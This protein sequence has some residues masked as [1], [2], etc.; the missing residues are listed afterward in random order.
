[1]LR[2][3]SVPSIIAAATLATLSLSARAV[4]PLSVSVADRE[5]TAQLQVP[6]GYAAELT[7]RFENVVGLSKD[8]LDIS[9]ETVS[10]L[11]TSLLQRLSGIGSIPMGFPMLLAIEVDPA[12][13]FSF[14]GTVDIELYTHDLKFVPGMPLRL[15]SAA[16]GGTFHDITVSNEGGS[17]RSG[18]TKGNFSDFIIALDLRPPQQAAGDKLQRLRSLL[19]Q[20]SADL[21]ASIYADLS[22]RLSE[23]ETAYAAN[24]L[25]TAVRYTEAFADAVKNYGADIP[26]VW[27]A[28][29]DLDN[30]SGELRAAA[31]TLRFS[32]TLAL[33]SL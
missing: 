17:Y 19:D 14:S 26:N 5:L 12:S 30:I 9:A 4:E 2:R 10:L 31:G 24:S 23:V 6:G 18:G 20:Y 3:T 16:H 21:D 13:G 22:G 32:L 27:G 8:S 7:L 25:V 33:N 1:M 29:H 15:Y 28:A 11:D